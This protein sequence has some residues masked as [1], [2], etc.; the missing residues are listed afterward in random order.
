LLGLQ[1]YFK[2]GLITALTPATVKL[3]FD[4]RRAR[5][6]QWLFTTDRIPARGQRHV[7]DQYFEF[8]E[9]LGIDPEP[10]TWG[11]E[12]SAEER[13]AQDG[14]LAGLDRPACVKRRSEER[15]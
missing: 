8:L 11:L 9:Y 10:V 3:G 13:A 14:F 7:Q 15:R 6:G 1:V 2:A 5:D 4:V 12:L